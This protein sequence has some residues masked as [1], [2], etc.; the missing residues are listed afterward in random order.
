MKI[1][2]YLFLLL[3][4][5][6]FNSNFRLKS[7]RDEEN[8]EMNRELEKFLNTPV[9]IKHKS[10]KENN[11]MTQEEFKKFLNTPV[12]KNKEM[13]Q[14]ELEEFLN[15]PLKKLK[16]TKSYMEKEPIRKY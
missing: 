12:Y 7:K 1:I 2:L 13:T 5:I 3:E 4:S 16:L 15:T 14:E 11:E 8:K 9:Y 6:V 10:E